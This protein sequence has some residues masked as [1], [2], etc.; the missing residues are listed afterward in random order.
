MQC[1]RLIQYDESP[2]PMAL[3]VRLPTLVL[4]ALLTGNQE[5]AQDGLGETGHVYLVGDDFLM[6]SVA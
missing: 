5:W 1:L 3:A 4:S 6:R 2:R